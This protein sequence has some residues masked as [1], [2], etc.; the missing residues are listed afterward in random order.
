MGGRQSPVLFDTQEHMR[1]PP[2]ICNENRPIVCGLFCTASILIEF[3]TRERR[4][5]RV[6]TLLQLREVD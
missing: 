3:P 1:W 4:N 6:E 2:A 5:R